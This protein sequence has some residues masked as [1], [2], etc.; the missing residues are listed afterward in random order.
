MAKEDKGPYLQPSAL[1]DFDRCPAIR[2]KSRELSS[3]CK[4]NEEKFRRISSFV[5]ELPYGL[6]DWDVPASLTLEKGWGMCSGKANLL[7]AMLRCCGIP[8]RYRI[9]AIEA[10]H[11]LW[12]KIA[13][14]Q[15]MGSTLG[16]SPMA[17]DHVDCEAWLGQWVACDPSRDTPLERGLLAMG[18]PLERKAMVDADGQVPY[19]RLASFDEWARERQARRRFR[20][21]RSETFGRINEVLRQIREAGGETSG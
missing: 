21:G 14:L 20:E 8:S 11:R 7:V 18:I 17:Q 12:E 16:D 19:L 1:C 3:V 5:K 10:E 9:Y 2:E 13:A 4:S 15:D 6:D